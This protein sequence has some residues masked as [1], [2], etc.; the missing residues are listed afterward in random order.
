M[1]GKNVGLAFLLSYLSCA[2]IGEL[3]LELRSSAGG[4]HVDVASAEQIVTGV[5]GGGIL[6]RRKSVGFLAEDG[7]LALQEVAGRRN[8][9]DINVLDLGLDCSGVVSLWP[10][11]ARGT[12]RR[13][14]YDLPPESNSS[15]EGKRSAMVDWLV[16][17]NGPGFSYG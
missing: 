14:W 8:V 5:D 15:N 3:G 13:G 9:A 2:D 4:G 16:S 12:N 1:S 6:Y 7:F 17:N 10:K 11:I